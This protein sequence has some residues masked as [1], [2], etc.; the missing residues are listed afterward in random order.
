MDDPEYHALYVSAMQGFVDEVFVPDELADRLTALHELIA[1][2]VV[3]DNGEVEG[4][5]YLD[6]ESAFED[7]LPGLIAY[8]EERY[9]L[10]QDYL[11]SQ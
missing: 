3:G 1:P 6:S 10:A 7:S 2:Y 4:Y 8:V 9:A 5:T 11:S